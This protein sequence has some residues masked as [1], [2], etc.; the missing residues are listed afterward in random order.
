MTKLEHVLD[1]G[2]NLPLVGRLGQAPRTTGPVCAVPG[3]PPFGDYF[4]PL[5]GN[6]WRPDIDKMRAACINVVKLYA[7]D[8]DK[9][10]GEPGSAGKWKEFLDYCYNN[11]DRP[12]YVV[13]FSF[14]LGGEIANGAGLDTYIKQYTALV[15]STVNHKAVF[16]YM[17]GNEIFGGGVTDNEQ[18]WTNFGKLIDAADEAGRSQGALPFLMTAIN[19]EFVE[20][21]W[22]AILK[23]EESHKLGNLDAWCINI[24]RGSQIGGNGNSPFTQYA[25]MM[26]KLNVPGVNPLILGEWGTPHT[27][28]PATEYSKP[29]ITPVINLDDVPESQMGKGKPYFDAVPVGDFLTEQWDTIKA[30]LKKPGYAH[31]RN[32]G[33][34]RVC[35]GRFIFD[36]CDEYW[37]GNNRGVQ[38]GGPNP[39]FLGAAFAGGYWDEAGFGVTGAVSGA[40][41][42]GRP[43]F[44]GYNAMK[45]FYAESSH[46]GQELYG[47]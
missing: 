1:S 46:R 33:A 11:G 15:K 19:D 18:F 31:N 34:V 44:K 27:T 32:A 43:L 10:A 40:D 39:G 4:T 16:G 45:S 26:Q 17:I 22:K 41:A 7:G 21:R 37:K 24:Y 28:R 20:G 47:E 25:E 6:V 35:V 12:I 38:V 13:M 30:N 5:Y 9:N 14:T 36:W 42:S 29:A 8:P 3:E 23:G 2:R